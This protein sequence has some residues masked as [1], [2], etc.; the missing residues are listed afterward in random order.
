MIQYL[1]LTG[2]G[3]FSLRVLAILASYWHICDIILATVASV[4]ES[5]ST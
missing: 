4:K 5:L 2:L 3:L 1:K